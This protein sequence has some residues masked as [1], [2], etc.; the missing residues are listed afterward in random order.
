MFD[1]AARDNSDFKGVVA[2]NGV[3]NSA[4]FMKAVEVS[5]NDVK[6]EL[7]NTYWLKY[8]ELSNCN[9]CFSAQIAPGL[10]FW[11]IT[12][13]KNLKCQNHNECFRTDL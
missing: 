7:Y 13:K 8:L 11:M 12:K 2:R 1:F 4:K 9:V 10:R 3:V 5:L 6:G